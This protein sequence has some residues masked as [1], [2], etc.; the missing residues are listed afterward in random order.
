M[1]SRVSW[2]RHKHFVNKLCL[3]SLLDISKM[4]P[5]ANDS[6]SL[7][8]WIKNYFN[9]SFFLFIQKMDHFV[10]RS[11]MIFSCFAWNMRY[12][13]IT[14]KLTKT[15]GPFYFGTPTLIENFAWKQPNYTS[16]V[17]LKLNPLFSLNL[18]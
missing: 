13:I 11:S 17:F 2:R 14:S 8:E 7:I 4:N 16:A 12:Q 9:F 18:L 6:T 15:F 1:K 5:F 10:V 3:Q